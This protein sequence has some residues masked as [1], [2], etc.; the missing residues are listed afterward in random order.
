MLLSSITNFIP[1]IYIASAAGASNSL[2]AS[3]PLGSGIETLSGNLTDRAGMSICRRN[4]ST[5]ENDYVD[6]NEY[7]DTSLTMIAFDPQKALNTGVSSNNLDYIDKSETSNSCV[8]ST[9]FDQTSV[10]NENA[11]N[12][13]VDNLVNGNSNSPGIVNSFSETNYVDESA[14]TFKASTVTDFKSSIYEDDLNLFDSGLTMNL[15]QSNFNVSS[16][17]YNSPIH[18]DLTS[19]AALNRSSAASNI[20][21][22]GS[23]VNTSFPIQN[24]NNNFAVGFAR[25]TGSNMLWFSHKNANLSLNPISPASVFGRIYKNTITYE[26]VYPS[27]D[28][29]YTLERN[30]LKE[31]IIVQKYTGVNEFNFQLSVN[32]AVY[33]KNFSGEIR[34]LD[35]GSSSPLFY[36]AKPF[37]V[38]KDGNRCDLVSIVI[39]ETGSLKLTVDPDWLRKAVYPIIIDPTIYLPDTLFTRSSVAYNLQGTQI[40]ANQPRYE[41]GKFGQAIM[42]E[43]G[44]TNL[45]TANQV[46]VETDTTGLNAIGGSITRNITNY[47]NGNASLECTTPGR[48]ASEGM[49]TEAVM[50]SVSPLTT[51]TLSAY[52]KGS[53]GAVMLSAREETGTGVYIKDTQG[54]AVALTPSW[55][56]LILTITTTSTTKRLCLFVATTSAQAT[57]FYYDGGQIEQKTYA[58]S[59]QLPETARAAETL[60]IPAASVLNASEG[61]IEF[62][63]A[64]DSLKQTST[65]YQAIFCTDN[66]YPGSR[67]LIMRDA[68]QSGRISVW[69]G[70]GSTEQSFVSNIIPQNGSY[71]FVTFTWSSAGRYLYINGQQVGSLSRT[72]SIG[73]AP[74]IHIG[75]WGSGSQLNGKID[76]LRISNRARTLAEHQAAYNNS[77]PLPIDGITTCKMSFDGNLYVASH[78]V[79]NAGITATFNRSSAAYKQNGTQVQMNQPRYETSKFGQAIMIEEGTTNKIVNGNFQSSF[80]SWTQQG[81]PATGELSEIIA[82]GVRKVYHLYKTSELNYMRIYQNTTLLASTQYTVSLY[83]KGIGNVLIWDGTSL[84]QININGPGVYT[85]YTATFTTSTTTTIGI[86]LSINGGGTGTGECWFGDVSVEQKAYPTSFQDSIR[87]AETMTIPT[88]DILNANKGSI[89]VIAYI[90]PTG[91]HSANN[92]NWSMIFAMADVQQSPYQEKNQISIRRSPNST[93]WGVWF[94]NASSSCAAVNLGNITTAG[95]YNFGVTWQAG[96]GGYGYLNGVNKGYVAASYLPTTITAPIAYIGSWIGGMFQHNQ[97]IDELRI[98]CRLRTADEILSSYQSNQPL[99]VDIDTTYKLNFNDDTQRCNFVYEYDEDNRLNKIIENGTPIFEFIYD[100][101]GNLLSKRKL[102]I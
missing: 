61:S 99:S 35:P 29:R 11:G 44:T 60:S 89:E 5:T 85:K 87:A 33:D 91:V 20:Y 49:G 30:R 27:T 3:N 66:I 31:D 54:P 43:E 96:V 94:S 93:N 23:N 38:D 36:I 40:Q 55:Q 56:R 77:Q 13:S 18:G 47:W 62:S 25:Q 45:L 97:L 19:Q 64:F 41:A 65:Q 102:G 57:T 53:S 74:D 15:N 26:N 75:S 37:A 32:N 78:D 17:V 98:S 10:L 101:N 28:I 72:C 46:S 82:D 58:T 63:V 69:D 59:C 76:D 71:Y 4:E 1:N 83:A 9:V 73:F 80:T 8:S 81:A 22:S 68:Y 95:W 51:Y 100:D 86:Y 79:I 14:N 92:P 7:S 24:K 16:S 39:A 2:Q 21:S 42:I 88:A 67:L 70:D 34:F 6:Q 90:D 84:A 48:S 12:S 52:V 50:T